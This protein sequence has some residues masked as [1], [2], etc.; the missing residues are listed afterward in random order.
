VE[1][2]GSVYNLTHFMEIR[3]VSE[4]DV[5]PSIHVVEYGDTL[6]SIAQRYGVSV[7]LL[8]QRNMIADPEMIYIGAKL[9]IR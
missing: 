3:E 6:S 5:T 7:A 1:S 8:L 2:G 9:R 4:P